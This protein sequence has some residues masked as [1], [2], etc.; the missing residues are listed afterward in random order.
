MNMLVSSDHS[1]DI[2][3]S[4]EQRRA[5]HFTSKVAD[6]RLL[7]ASAQFHYIS[8][9]ACKK[10]C[11]LWILVFSALICM[12]EQRWTNTGIFLQIN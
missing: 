9:E 2:H 1:F 5:A 12:Q 11:S 3:Y 8:V 10:D 4:T 6:K 7:N